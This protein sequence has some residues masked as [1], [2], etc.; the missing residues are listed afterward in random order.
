MTTQERKEW[1]K[2]IYN[3]AQKASDISPI[4]ITAQAALETG[5][6]KSTIGKY[7]LFGVTK[8]TSWKGKTLLITTSEIFTTDKK[9]FISPEEVISIKKLPSGKYLYKVKRLFRDYSSLEECLSDHMSILQKPGYADAWPYR[10]SPEE[11]ARRISDCVGCKY[12]TDPNY[13]TLMKSMFYS[14]RKLL[15]L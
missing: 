5:W 6:G 2:A 4:F 3:S 13:A 11:F 12:A 7:N 8:G 15:Q 14:V 9:K 1:A 10:K